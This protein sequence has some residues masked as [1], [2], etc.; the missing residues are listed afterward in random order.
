[1]L[2]HIDKNNMPSMVDV[3]DKDSTVRVAIA[4]STIQLPE[5]MR[6]YFVGEDFVLK[7]GPV[8]QTAIIAA[9]MAVK[10]TYEAIPMCHQ[11]PIESCKVNIKSNSD[12]K[13]TVEC[14]VKTS[15]KTGIE[16]EALHGAMIAC[17]TIYDMCKAVS[18]KM[19]IGE[20]KLLF[21]SGGKKVVLN[22]PVRGLILT[23]GK[24][25]RMKRDKALIEYH[26]VPHARYIKNILDTYCD[27]VFLSAKEGQWKESAISDIPVLE[28]NPKYE[29]PM[30]GI[31]S[32]FEKYPESN[33]L[34]VACDLAYFNR[35]T[36]EKLIENYQ[37]DKSGVAYKNREKGFA[38]PLCSLYTPRSREIFKLA[39]ENGV[40]CP[41]KV[42]LDSDI[43]KLEQTDGINLA[44]INTPEEF[45]EV[46]FEN[47]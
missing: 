3:S 27:E 33:W 38:E 34:I 42:L 16:M 1:M 5:E 44:N 47:N 39:S 10:K 14:K 12:L 20:T 15:Y 28:D 30:S 8:F 9:T 2:T 43:I 17:L 32:A 26:G 31:L 11:V 13:V 4:Q 25:Q 36:V 23:G 46:K 19:I 18:H 35:E 22:K 29:G 21:K 6:E 41:V 7:K 45:L 40:R 37:E 24:S